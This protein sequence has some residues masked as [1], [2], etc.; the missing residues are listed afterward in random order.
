MPKMVTAEWVREQVEAIRRI[1]GD[2]EAAHA[3]EDDLHRE[4]LSAIAHGTCES[5]VECA[6]LA[7]TTCEIDFER[8]Y[9]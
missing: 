6:R 3:E 8:W 2:N 4:V 7:L 1:A 9:A 5:P